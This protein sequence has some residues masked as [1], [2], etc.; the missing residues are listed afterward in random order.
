[1]KRFKVSTSSS[2]E[3]ILDHGLLGNAG[4]LISQLGFPESTSTLNKIALITDST[5]GELYA[6][7]IISDL[8][9]AGFDVYKILF[10]A[11][12]HS[13][14]LNTYSNILESLADVGMSRSDMVLA[15]GGGVVMDIAGFAAGTYLRGIRYAAIPTTF[16]AAMDAAIGGK[17]GVNLLKGKN[18]AG[19]FWQPSLVLCDLDILSSSSEEGL[20][21]GLA[22]AIKCAAISDGSLLKAI[23]KG[24]LPYI[25]ERCISIKKSLI[26]ADERGSNLRQLL[27]FGHTIG[28]GIEKLSSYNISHGEA[29]AMGMVIEARGAWL[30]GLTSSDISGDL[31][32]ILSSLG[33]NLSPSYEGEE[34]YQAALSDEKISGGMIAMTIPESMGK[35]TIKKISLGQ[36]RDLIAAGVK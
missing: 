21:E 2:Y 29:I 9:S 28:H 15:L 4:N 5:V 12:E 6:G 16:Q 31:S 26:E 33:F 27:D 22:E 17:T 18:L 8:R 10:P 30:T 14:N 13:K 1:M 20:T 23:E 19:V 24:D 35:A 36:L 3:V 34:L 25:L 32:E 11:G 7:D